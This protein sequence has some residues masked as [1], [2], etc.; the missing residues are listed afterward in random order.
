MNKRK[1]ILI[2]LILFVPL[3][4]GSIKMG[5]VNGV[6]DDS[7]I[8]GDVRTS[9]VVV[10]NPAPDFN[11]TDV[12]S[13][14]TY[15]LT[16]F[17]GNFVF[18]DLWATWCGPC[19]ISLPFIS[20]FYG[21][22]ANNLTIISI[23]VDN[24]ETDNQ[25]SSFRKSHNMDWIVGIDYDGSINSIYGSGAIPTFY[26][27]NPSGI[28][29]W[30]FVGIDQENF[31]N[32]LYSIISTYIPDDVTTPSFNEFTVTN[33]TELSIFNPRVTVKA[34][35][36]EENHLVSVNLTMQSIHG[37]ITTPLHY[38]K[39]DGFCMFNQVIY[40]DPE[41]IFPLTTMNYEISVAD[42]WS[43]SNM[44][45]SIDI[46]VTHYV[47]TGPPTY[48]DVSVN[49]VQTSDTQYNVTIF[50]IIEEDLMLTRA[51]VLLKKGTSTVKA[52][53][54]EIYNGTHMV[55]SGIVLNSMAE[56]HEL[57]A[58]LV[59]ED[60]AGNEVTAD[61]TVADA[62]EETTKTSFNYALVFVG[63]IFSVVILRE[64]RK[65]K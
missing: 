10:G 30:Y 65:R 44:S 47:D 61:F 16:Q 18:L 17:L 13:R 35:I 23:D 22:Y 55:A 48:S 62:P 19:E 53:S 9:S 37:L 2:I 28:I 52:E 29:E 43:H 31:F 27:I 36:S 41:F 1:T 26:L 42:F 20:Q 7:M 8:Y 11:I 45:S 3:L 12:D 4:M 15:N 64:F 32:D 21:M 57:L 39:V 51:D 24:S 58:R 50:V 25:V 5:P 6:I 63:F 60:I 38:E 46:D 34:N 54:F 14:I 33:S 49:Y 59:L 40:Y 56:P